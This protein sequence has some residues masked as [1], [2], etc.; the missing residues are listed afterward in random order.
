MTIALIAPR[1]ACESERR[2]GLITVQDG[3][4]VVGL[5]EGGGRDP[6]AAVRGPHFNTPDPAVHHEPIDFVDPMPELVE[7]MLDQTGVKQGIVAPAVVVFLH[8]GG[9]DKPRA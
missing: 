2:T 9:H 3:S 8:F 1:L 5:P 4:A 7:E 6:F